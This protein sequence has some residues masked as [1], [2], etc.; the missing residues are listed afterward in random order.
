MDEIFSLNMNSVRYYRV[1][2]RFVFY[3]PQN[4]L[5]F[6]LQPRAQILCVQGRVC[7]CVCSFLY[8]FK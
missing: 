2:T 8:I 7:V 5:Y 6:T 3:K 4:K 1:I